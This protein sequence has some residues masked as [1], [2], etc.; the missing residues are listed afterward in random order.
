MAAWN[1]G[2]VVGQKQWNDRLYSLY[3]DAEIAPYEAG[4]FAKLGL[5]IGGEIIGRPY[6]LVNPPDRRPLLPVVA[7]RDA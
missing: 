4:Q 6:S 2:R 5:Q 7:R 1:E 3:V